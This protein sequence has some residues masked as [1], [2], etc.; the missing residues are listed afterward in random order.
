[1]ACFDPMARPVEVSSDL[2]ESSP[3]DTTAEFCCIGGRA[4]L[5]DL[6][7]NK[8]TQIAHGDGS[9]R[10]AKVEGFRPALAD[11]S[12]NGERSAEGFF[13]GLFVHARGG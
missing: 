3:F 8:A 10:I 5:L 9:L 12:S 6:H 2:S 7:C 11:W 13:Q 1:M 4:R